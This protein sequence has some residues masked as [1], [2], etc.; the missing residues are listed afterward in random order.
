MTSATSEIPDSPIT[1]SDSFLEAQ[2]Y[3]PGIDAQRIVGAGKEDE[4]R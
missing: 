3:K 1:I 4:E 2:T